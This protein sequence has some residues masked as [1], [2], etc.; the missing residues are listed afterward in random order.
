[1]TDTR[2]DQPDLTAENLATLMGLT[3]RQVKD[4]V[5]K[6]IFIC[7]WRGNRRGM[8]F[9]PDDVEYNRSLGASQQV[10]GHAMPAPTGQVHKGIARLRKAGAA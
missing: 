1:M 6:E 4:R 2:L 3:T 9:T 5:A 8:R 10:A 7:H